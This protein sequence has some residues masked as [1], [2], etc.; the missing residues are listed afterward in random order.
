MYL[1]NA[2]LGFC[3]FDWENSK[4]RK[5]EKHFWVLSGFVLSEAERTETPK[6]IIIR[7]SNLELWEVLGGGFLKNKAFS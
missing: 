6:A 3:L 5:R 2:C 7:V 4:D 1:L